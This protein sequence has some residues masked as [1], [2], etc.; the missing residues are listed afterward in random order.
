VSDAQPAGE[1]RTEKKKEDGES[2]KREKQEM[3]Q[4]VICTGLAN[5]AETKGERKTSERK[6][7]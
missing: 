6:S 7:K 5:G 1:S 3:K 4:S 2:R